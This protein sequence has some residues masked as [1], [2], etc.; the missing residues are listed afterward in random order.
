[1]SKS[2]FIGI[3]R[4]TLIPGPNLTVEHTEDGLMTARMEFHCPTIEYIAATANLKRGKKLSTLFPQ[5][6]SIYSDLIVK[7]WVNRGEKGGLSYVEVS[8]VGAVISGST[9]NG[10]EPL[11]DDQASIDDSV[12]ITEEEEATTES[13]TDYTINK[14]EKSV[15]FSRSCSLVEKDIFKNPMFKK[16][17]TA[18]QRRLIK[19]VVE[20]DFIY[21]LTSTDSYQIRRESNKEII[22]K[23]EGANPAAWFEKIVCDNELTYEDPV[24]EWTKS[25]TG[26]GVLTE[27]DLSRFGRV[28]QTPPGSPSKPGN[29]TNWLFTG[30][31]ESMS[32][33]DRVNSYS[34]TWTSGNYDVKTHGKA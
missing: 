28:W 21:E 27:A 14:D 17:T 11:T 1:M 12:D 9:T 25:A 33:I 4:A 32:K 16:E 8:F 3:P 6:L 26:K 18:E 19:G 24:T 22:G 7:S 29:A 5:V 23:V 31:T 30:I 13:S 20:K 15:V 2:T 34:M 10:T